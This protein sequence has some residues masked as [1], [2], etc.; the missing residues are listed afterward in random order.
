MI[1][2]LQDDEMIIH[3]TTNMVIR[4]DIK[5]QNSQN[6]PSTLGKESSSSLYFCLGQFSPPNI[7]FG[8]SYILLA[9]ADRRPSKHITVPPHSRNSFSP[10]GRRCHS[11][12]GGLPPPPGVAATASW[13][14]AAATASREGPPLT[15]GQ[16]LLARRPS[17]LVAPALDPRR[18]RPCILG[19]AG[20]IVEL[21]MLCSS[22][23]TPELLLIDGSAKGRRLPLPP[24]SGRA[25]I[26]IAY[27]ILIRGFSLDVARSMDLTFQ[28][29]M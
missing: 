4:L 27:A 24:Q 12:L 9:H 7:Q 22:P 10:S 15:H 5:R 16:K 3:T 1:I 18:R 26:A 19:G 25:V 21:L 8:F 28:C 20:T 11:K 23:V 14:P 29:I 13:E 2:H 17:I 6:R